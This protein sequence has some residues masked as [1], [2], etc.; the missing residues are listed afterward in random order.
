MYRVFM[1]TAVVFYNERATLQDFASNF[2]NN[3]IQRK[4]LLKIIVFEFKK[5]KKYVLTKPRVK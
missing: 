3:Y 5:F 1:A 4:N 2:L